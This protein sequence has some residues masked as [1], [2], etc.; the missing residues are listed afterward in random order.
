MESRVWVNTGCGRLTPGPVTRASTNV[1]DTCQIVLDCGNVVEAVPE[2]VPCVQ[3]SQGY[4]DLPSELQRKINQD[5]ILSR[6]ESEQNL[7]KLRDD[8]DETLTLIQIMHQYG[9]DQGNTF[10]QVLKIL[11]NHEQRVLE[12]NKKFHEDFGQDKIDLMSGLLRQ[13]SVNVA[14]SNMS[15]FGTM[16]AAT[17]AAFQSDADKLREQ[18]KSSLADLAKQKFNEA[19]S[20]YK[21]TFTTL[22]K[23]TAA[24][25]ESAKDSK[26]AQSKCDEYMEGLCKNTK[27]PY[28]MF[29]V[30]QALQ[31]DSK[32]ASQLIDCLLQNRPIVG[33]NHTISGMFHVCAVHYYTDKDVPQKDWHDILS[34]LHNFQNIWRKTLTVQT[35]HEDWRDDVHEAGWHGKKKYTYN[36]RPY[37]DGEFYSECFKS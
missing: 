17:K 2:A 24:Y 15:L 30:C 16:K 22:D 4:M 6:V 33:V 21:D 14:P 13:S 27:F 20:K 26:K 35:K 7:A 34:M 29:Q 37:S 12:A 1:S 3:Q 9:L 19:A 28:R 8:V 32:M 25:L 10:D 36:I 31:P 18:I 5:L 11:Y 23:N